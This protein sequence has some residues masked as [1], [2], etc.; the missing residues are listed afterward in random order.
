[1]IGGIELRN[2]IGPKV[3]IRGVGRDSHLP[4]KSKKTRKIGYRDWVKN[5]Y[6]ILVESIPDIENLIY[7]T[8][9]SMRS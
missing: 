8:S 4:N 5:L 3:C 6:T 1:M 2:G 7:F 9:Y